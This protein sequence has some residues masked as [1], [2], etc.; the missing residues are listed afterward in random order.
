MKSHVHLFLYVPQQNN[1]VMCGYYVMKFMS[2]IITNIKIPIDD[3]VISFTHIH[4]VFN[5]FEFVFVNK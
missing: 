4:K 1:G 5:I 2:E 3:V